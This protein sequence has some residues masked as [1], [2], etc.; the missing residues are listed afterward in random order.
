MKRG[1]A[2]WIASIAAAVFVAWIG[3]WIPLAQ[4]FQF[5]ADEGYELMKGALVSRGFDLYNPIWNDQPPLHTQLLG[6]I[7]RLFGP[8]VFAARLLTVAFAAL[9]VWSF[10]EVVRRSGGQLAAIGGTSVLVAWPYFLQLSVSAMIE[11]PA[12]AVGMLSLW[13]LVAADP[14]RRKR[15][16]VISGLIMGLALQTKLTAVILI[17]PSIPYLVSEGSGDRESPASAKARWKARSAGFGIWL[18]AL[19]IGFVAVAVCCSGESF[20]VFWKSHFSEQMRQGMGN[21]GDGFRAGSLWDQ[22]DFVIPALVG[23]AWCFWR[24]GKDHAAPILF[25]LFVFGIHEF[26]RPYWYYYSVHFGLAIAWLAGIGVS[27][28]FEVIWSARPMSNRRQAAGRIVVLLFWSYLAALIVVG[29]LGRIQSETKA[30][31]R[32]RT[33]RESA[34]VRELAKG[35]ASAGWVFT[36]RVIYAFHAGRLVPPELAVIPQKRIWS[37]Q[38]SAEEIVAVLGRYEPRDILLLHR[39]TDQP[40]LKVYLAAH[41]DLIH[42]QPR[43]FRRK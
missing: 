9:L 2:H 3:C 14:G 19:V 20:G 42:S 4:A 33:I 32:S 7:F 28:L 17:A 29:A 12:M 34:E 36:D 16:L 15:S 26:H 43:H 39:W 41:Y 35:E 22:S 11:I 18:A 25:L 10:Y 27:R 1:E 38:I 6:A 13:C 37:G 31:A 8:S 40:L 5:G 24:F 30:L 21:L 23:L